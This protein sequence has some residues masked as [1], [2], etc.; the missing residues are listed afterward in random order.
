MCPNSRLP[1]RHSV[2]SVPILLGHWSL[3]WAL[4]TPVFGFDTV[5]IPLTSSAVQGLVV[6]GTFVHLLKLVTPLV[7]PQNV[8]P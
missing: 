2:D 7:I 1:F 5:V 4:Y 8:R 3:Y 6:P